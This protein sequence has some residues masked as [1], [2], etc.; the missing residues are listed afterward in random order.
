MNLHFVFRLIKE[1]NSRSLDCFMLVPFSLADEGLVLSMFIFVNRTMW[2]WHY[3]NDL[4]QTTFYG[5]AT[6]SHNTQFSLL[7]LG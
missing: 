5:D 1:E 4:L 3:Y 7:G 2:L 6:V